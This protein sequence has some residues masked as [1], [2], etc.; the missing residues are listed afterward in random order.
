M[1]ALIL[2]AHGSKVKECLKSVELHKRRIE[3]LDLFDEIFIA[4]L[5]FD[6]SLDEIIE[7][8]RSSVVYVVPLFMS[9]GIHT[10]EDIPKI[11]KK[12]KNKSRKKIILCEP[13]GTDPLITYAILNKVMEKISGV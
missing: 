6:P 4:F 12:A 5:E 1:R 2:L 9:Y 8:C 13:V 7:K 3:K 10:L 11:V